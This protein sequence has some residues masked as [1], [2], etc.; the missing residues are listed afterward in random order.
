MKKIYLLL[1]LVLT[2]QSFTA[3]AQFTTLYLYSRSYPE[4]GCGV[5]SFSEIRLQEGFFGCVP[6]CEDSI[7][8]DAYFG[9]GTDT[10]YTFFYAR[11]PGPSPVWP[12]PL[13]DVPHQYTMAGSFISKVVVTTKGGAKDSA[14][15]EFKIFDSCAIVKG[16]LFVDDNGNCIADAGEIAL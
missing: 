10:S 12:L 1:L 16:K 7:H 11:T 9:D 13:H 15:N 5:P 6:K 2:S 4:I 14:L 3:K 8:I